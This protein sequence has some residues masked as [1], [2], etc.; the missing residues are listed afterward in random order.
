[1]NTLL[2]YGANPT[3]FDASRITLLMHTTLHGHAATT[4][5][6]LSVG[7]PWN[8]LSPSNPSADDL[9][10]EHDHQEAFDVLLNAACRR[11][12]SLVPS[13]ERSTKETG[14]DRVNWRRGCPL[15]STR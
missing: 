1:M 12:S 8:A 5:I 13:L 3:Y 15:A 9:S 4:S 14:E 10:M 2:S 7:A 11:S 6:L